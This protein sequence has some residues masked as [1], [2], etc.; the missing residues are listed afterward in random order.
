[1]TFSARYTASVRRSV[2]GHSPVSRRGEPICNKINLMSDSKGRADG[3]DA[4]SERRDSLTRKDL[5]TAAHIPSRCPSSP[6]V[7]FASRGK[8]WC[9]PGASYDH[10]G[11][12]PSAPGRAE[13]FRSSAMTPGGLCTGTDSLSS[14]THAVLFGWQASQQ[15]GCL[16]Q[17]SL[18]EERGPGSVSEGLF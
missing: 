10:L 6:L 2:T 16:L 13:R 17:K 14:I 15:A 5:F 7:Y 4:R 8:T 11:S 1:M 3:M 12:I 18:P 9:G